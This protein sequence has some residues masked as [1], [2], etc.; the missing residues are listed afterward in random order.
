MIY[1]LTPKKDKNMR[2]IKFIFILFLF[3]WT[4]LFASGN[5]SNFELGSAT[6]RDLSQSAANMGLGNHWHAAMF[7]YFEYNSSNETGYM[8]YTE[9]TINHGGR[10]SSSFH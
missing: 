3:V 8:R 6:Y 9:S 7:D 1:K 4:S 5:I 2:K 10:T